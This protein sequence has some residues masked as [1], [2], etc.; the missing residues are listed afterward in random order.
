M[1]TCSRDQCYII[2]NNSV[3]ATSAPCSTSVYITVEAA[4]SR[5]ILRPGIQLVADAMTVIQSPCL[6]VSVHMTSLED[7]T[8]RSQFEWWPS[9]LREAL[10]QTL[11]K[12]WLHNCIKV[13]RSVCSLP[14]VYQSLASLAFLATCHGSLGLAEIH[15]TNSRKF[16][17]S[18]TLC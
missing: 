9:S 7:P 8:A 15:M 16:Q 11:T 1:P 5:R 4:N 3:A 10:N 6:P 12:K 18:G 14:S 13:S 17:R 2:L